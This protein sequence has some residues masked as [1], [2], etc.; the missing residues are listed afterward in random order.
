LDGLALLFTEGYPAGTPMLRRALSAFR[1]EDVSKEEGL[2]W[3]WLACRAAVDLWDDE[4]WYVLSTRH[5]QLARD[6]GALSVLPIALI[7]RMGVYLWTGELSAAASLNHEVEA[8]TEATGSHLA[9]YG[10]LGLAAWRGR[11]AETFEL[12]KTSMKEVVARGEGQGL[13]LMDWTS[14]V[15]YNGV[16]RYEDALDAAQQAGEHPEELPFAWGLVELIEAATRSGKPARAADALQRLSETTRAS[17]T[18]WALGIEARSRA[19]LSDGE[20]AERLYR[21]AIDRLGH[22]RVRWALARAHLLYGEWLRRE[23]RRIDAR[24]QLRTAHRMLTS[25]GAHGFAERA[26]RELRA[27]GERVRKRTTETPLQLTARE[28]QIGR[29]AGDGLSNPDIAAQLFM[30]RRTVEYHLHKIFTKLAITSRNQLHSVL[31]NSRTEG[32]RQAP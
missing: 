5:V 12:I 26:A 10:A 31:A 9:P 13:A 23:N 28:T 7:S 1:S 19:L 22:T 32:L 11:E 4:T 24:E 17:G 6:A 27:T 14:A 3:L 8:V 18:D 21:E 2:R 25:I 20:A 15:L 16:G 29:L 30:S